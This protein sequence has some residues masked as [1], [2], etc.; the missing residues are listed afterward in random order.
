MATPA[1]PGEGV[2][3][4]KRFALAE[5]APEDWQS[6]RTQL[7]IGEGL[8]P[9]GKPLPQPLRTTLKW[10]RKVLGFTRSEERQGWAL[11]LDDGRLLGPASLLIPPRETAGATLE[12]AGHTWEAN[13]EELPSEARLATI[14]APPEVHAGAAA[15]PRQRIREAKEPED[16]VFVADVQAPLPVS[17]AALAATASGWTVD[18]SLPLN[19]E[20]Q[21]AC[22]VSR[23]DGAVV[24]IVLVE[25]GQAAV[26][27]LPQALLQVEHEH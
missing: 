6:W 9:E 12:A 1:P 14:V 16:C 5:Q 4:G 21:G 10:K 25:K 3:T 20:W 18:A 11:P 23:R 15:W 22:V 2:A 24:G 27:L 7:A 17:T 19:A 8:L 13:G 26:A